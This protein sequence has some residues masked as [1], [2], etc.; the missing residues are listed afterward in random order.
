MKSYVHAGAR[1]AA[2]TSGWA[3]ESCRACSFG[4]IAIA[5]IG[6]GHYTVNDR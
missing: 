5:L 6:P 1:S 4:A 2:A 3:L